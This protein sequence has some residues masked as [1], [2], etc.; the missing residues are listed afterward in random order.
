MKDRINKLM[1]S[2]GGLKKGLIL[3]PILFS[4]TNA[5]LGYENFGL[6]ISN[7]KSIK[8]NLYYQTD[9]TYAKV[10]L[11]NGS[12]TIYSLPREEAERQMYNLVKTSNKEDIWIYFNEKLIDLGFDEKKEMVF[13]NRTLLDSLV[14]NS[15]MDTL[16]YYHIHKNQYDPP[17]PEDYEE[18]NELQQM[19]SKKG[20]TLI[21]KVFDQKGCWIYGVKK[22]NEQSSR[23]LAQTSIILYHSI[24]DTT[25]TEMTKEE[26]LKYIQ[27]LRDKGYEIEFQDMEKK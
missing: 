11:V 10:K 26:S 18:D 17:S 2:S 5:V 12:G 9:T 15:K 16:Y 23:V 24:I 14:N 8:Y 6:K 25:K 4:L 20:I 22:V 27:N 1:R 21:S 7:T 3:F 13:P 19:L